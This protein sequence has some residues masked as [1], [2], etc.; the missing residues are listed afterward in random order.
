ML[1]DI[2]IQYPIWYLLLCFLLG[3][4]YAT[5][6]YLRDHKFGEQRPWLPYILSFLRGSAVTGIA[7]LLLAPLLKTITQDAKRPIVVLAQDNSTSMSA[8]YAAS[9]QSLAT[10]SD[11]L[12]EL[13]DV[14]PLSFGSEIATGIADSAVEQS[15]DLSAVLAYIK[16]NYADQN[17]GAVVLASDG[18]YNEGRDPRY[19]KGAAA[20]VYTV[21]YGDTTKRRDISIKN[22]YA[23]RIA[24]LGDK[25]VMQ[26]D[27]QGYNAAGSGS[28]ISV[29]KVSKS[30]NQSIGSQAIS[31]SSNDYFKTFD[32]T[33]D[34]NQT[35]VIQYR[36][37]VSPVS[38]E[39][40]TSNNYKDIYVEV[41]DSRQRILLLTN[42]PHPD[43]AAIKSI[44]TTRKNYEVTVAYAK[45]AP[46][47]LRRYNLAIL[48]NLPSKTH[49]VSNLVDQLNKA[50]VP[51]L[52]ILGSQ[53]DVRELNDMQSVVSINGGG[54]VDE[55]QAELRPAFSSYI[56]EQDLLNRLR[57][58]PPLTAPFGE[59]KPAG[60]TEVVFT[61]RIKTV[62]TDYPL[63]AFA[64][65]GGRKTGILA[66]EGLWR[67]RLFNYMKEKNYNVVDEFLSKAVQ[68]LMVKDDRRKFR[69]A[70]NKNIYKERESVLLEAQLFNDSYEQINA[71]DVFVKVIAADG[72][73][74][75]FTMSRVDAYYSLDAGLFKPGQY[76][77][78]A[79]TNYGGK[80]LQQEGRFSV[81]EVQLEAYDLSAR[82]DVLYQLADQSGG[83]LYYPDQLAQLSTLLTETN[84]VKPVLYDSVKT[85]SVLNFKWLFAVLFAM[86]A[87]EWFLR[88]YYG[89]Y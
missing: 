36:V 27:V 59:Y 55:V 44:L 48:H 85:Q 31:I 8:Q 56:L 16:D 40:N 57:S 37:S 49:D 67:W 28:R 26:V 79:S 80:K 76:R 64:Q 6:L 21:A 83:S 19:V 43:V 66:G 10:L 52:F 7:I 69:A 20:K 53:V 54:N 3:A 78:I 89:Y 18:I 25:F 87:L 58:Y 4:I 70:I 75:D 23:N 61:Q 29:R 88:R 68:Y 11:E 14:V 35:G 65:Q 13:Y 47:D 73:E 77:Y 74:Y 9:A 60:T 62:G 81:R 86:L 34:A 72:K 12:S 45:E 2:S 39:V 32:F 82:H 1:G 46:A 24:Y 42:A 71:P 51:Q 63:L 5:F 30:G 22:V 15:T 41:L 33:I 38:G 84:V 50:L 17:L